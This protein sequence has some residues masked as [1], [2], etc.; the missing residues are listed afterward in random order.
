MGLSLG[1]EYQKRYSRVVIRTI[2]GSIRDKKM[3]DDVDRWKNGA[4]TTIF[5][6][7]L[8]QIENR[9]GAGETY[10]ATFPVD[11]DAMD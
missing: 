2:N 10:D 11:I 9:V 3:K 7:D 1:Q 5:R 4:R 8:L 6:Q